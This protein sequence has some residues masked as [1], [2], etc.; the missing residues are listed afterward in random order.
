MRAIIGFV[1]MAAGVVLGLYAGIW[2]AFIGGIVQ[3]IGEIR[4]EHLDAMNVAM[5]VARVV[6]T[7]LI[8]YLSAAILF[9]PGLVLVKS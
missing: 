6:F 9:L 4:A 3:V 7:G 2:W 8:G 1:L 5:G